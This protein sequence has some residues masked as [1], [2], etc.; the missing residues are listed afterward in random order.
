MVGATAGLVAFSLGITLIAGTVFGYTERAARDIR[1][2]DIYISS[3]L[4]GGSR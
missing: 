1:D 3:V 2:R 4:T